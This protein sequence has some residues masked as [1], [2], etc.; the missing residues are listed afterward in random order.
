ME[1]SKN[2]RQQQQHSTGSTIGEDYTIFRAKAL[3]SASPTLT[4][5]A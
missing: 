1:V 3:V 5:L 4:Q 2:D